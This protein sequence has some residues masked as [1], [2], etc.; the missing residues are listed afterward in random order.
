MGWSYRRTMEQAERTE[1]PAAL[2]HLQ[3][4]GPH[5]ERDSPW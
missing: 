2:V 3:I 4:A 1:T 5:A